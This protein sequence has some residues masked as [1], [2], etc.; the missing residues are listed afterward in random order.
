M[1]FVLLIIGYMEASSSPEIK[2]LEIDSRQMTK[3]LKAVLIADLHVA[4][5]GTSL[6]K[7]QDIVKIINEQKPDIIFIAGDFVSAKRLSTHKADFKEVANVLKG[8]ESRLGIYGVL[9]N[10]DHWKGSIEARKALMA[11]GINILDNQAVKV[12]DLVIGGVDD[13]F[14]G[15]ANVESTTNEMTR[16]SGFKILLSHS[17]D[18]MPKVP[19]NIP[20]VLAGH[21]HCGQI[22]FPYFG[23][24][25]TM[26]RYG[27]K[28]ACGVVEENGKMLVVTSG[29]GTSLFPVRLGA[30]PDI[31]VIDIS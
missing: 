28:Y 3:P 13:A 26:S 2:N 12:E 5:P 21:T 9:G 30:R 22:S 25:V 4:E 29:I 23:P 18:V 20:L 8:L 6:E 27:K 11:S 10:H 1:I 24:L 16:Y 31:W 17:P 14:T 15:H 7:V 19:S